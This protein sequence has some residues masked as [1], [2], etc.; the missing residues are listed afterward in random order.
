MISD[1]TMWRSW[2]EN[3]TRAIDVHQQLARQ[4]LHPLVQPAARAVLVLAA[5]E[6]QQ[7]ALVQALRVRDVVAVRGE[8]LG[9]ADGRHPLRARLRAIGL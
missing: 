2:Y 6:H 8:V 5:A 1:T 4:Q 7:R 3:S 9:G